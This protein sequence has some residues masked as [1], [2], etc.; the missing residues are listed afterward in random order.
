MSTLPRPPLSGHKDIAAHFLI[1]PTLQ[2]YSPSTLNELRSRGWKMHDGYSIHLDRVEWIPL[3]TAEG[4][5]RG[6]KRRLD[7]EFRM[8]VDGEEVGVVREDTGD[9]G[10][11]KGVNWNVEQFVPRKRGTIGVLG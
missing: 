10:G 6:R 3:G 1:L 2:H 5:W 8:E 9:I 7:E 11:F 4:G